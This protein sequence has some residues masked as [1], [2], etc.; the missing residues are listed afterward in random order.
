MVSEAQVTRGMKGCPVCMIFWR[1]L[2]K[3]G[4]APRHGL[5][6]LAGTLA[7]PPA[8][9]NLAEGFFRRVAGQGR[10]CGRV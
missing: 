7:R 5:L 8:Y 10:R 6:T 4:I 3:G 1:K 2:E 9:Y